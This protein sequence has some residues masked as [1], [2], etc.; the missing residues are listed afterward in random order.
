MPFSAGMYYAAF[1]G[2]RKEYPPVVLI[3]GAGGDHLYWPADFR[4]IPG[5]RILA[6]DLPGHG[7]STG[8]GKQ[9]IWAYADQLVHFLDELGIFR[10]I[11]IGYSLGGCI[12]L[13]LALRHPEILVAMGLIASGAHIDIPPEIIENA[14]NPL[15]FPQA[16][17]A[18]GDRFFSSQTDPRIIEKGMKHLAKIRLGV[19][20]GDLLASKAFDIIDRVGEIRAPALVM[21]GSEDVFTPPQ[22]SQFL[23]AH[24]G[25][26]G[27]EGRAGAET[28]LRLIPAA[29][30][31]VIL[32]Q[33]QAVKAQ[34]VPF[35]KKFCQG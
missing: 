4:R 9:S 25:S 10:A 21:C 14:A 5:C 3:H 16:I 7:L 17:S 29:G 30:H 1:E 2:D 19:L 20:Y 28:R 34:L 33:P 26:E 13:A 22:S 6:P 27:N 12:V 31:A 24:L 18:L 35:I 32:E 23:A 11:F 15:T 8:S